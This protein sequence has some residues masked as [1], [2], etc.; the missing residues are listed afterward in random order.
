MPMPMIAQASARLTRPEAIES[1]IRPAAKNR[2]VAARTSRPTVAI[3]HA[4]RSRSQ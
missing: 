1:T 2:L 3:D 4:S